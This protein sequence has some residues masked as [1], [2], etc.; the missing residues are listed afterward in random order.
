MLN[1]NYFN[2]CQEKKA[3]AT[4]TRI[5]PLRPQFHFDIATT[6]NRKL[7]TSCTENFSHNSKDLDFQ[8]VANVI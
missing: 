1:N 8:D 3:I 7:K 5:H 6:Y 2:S 4:Q